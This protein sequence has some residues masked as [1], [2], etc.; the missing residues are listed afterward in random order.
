MLS[1][2]ARRRA[3]SSSVTVPHMNERNLFERQKGWR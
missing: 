3:S 2:W 1:L